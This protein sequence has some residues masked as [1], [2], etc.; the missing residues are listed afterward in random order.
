MG[1]D[2]TAYARIKKLDAVFDEDGEP[3]DPTTREPLEYDFKAYQNPNFP[4]RAD[5]I[6]D[7]AVYLGEDSAGLSVGYG[8]YN[9]WRDE[10]AKAAGYPKG[11]YKQHGMDWE[12]H[13]VE[14]WNG[15]QGPFS[16]LINFSDCEGAIGTAVSAKL[17]RDFAEF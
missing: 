2:V 5:D 13:C 8:G 4:G 3:I 6:E 16:E 17:A 9:V 10:L 1:L 11:K 15:A 14:C 12:S 7:R